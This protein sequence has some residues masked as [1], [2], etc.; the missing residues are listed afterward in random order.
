MQGGRQEAGQLMSAE[1][2]RMLWLAWSGAGPA[3]VF[4][5]CCVAGSGKIPSTDAAG[6]RRDDVSEEPV[7]IA[8]ELPELQTHLQSGT[9]S[10]VCPGEEMSEGDK[11]KT[12]RLNFRSGQQTMNKKH[13]PWQLKPKSALL[14]SIND[15]GAKNTATDWSQLSGPGLIRCNL[16]KNYMRLVNLTDTKCPSYKKA[17]G[18]ALHSPHLC[19]GI[20]WRSCFY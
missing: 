5:R 16:R 3:R 9:I 1:A 6:T 17:F 19:V 18:I 13:I 14:F 8:R 11:D 10:P 2:S 20:K 15:S 7:I 4:Q 12:T